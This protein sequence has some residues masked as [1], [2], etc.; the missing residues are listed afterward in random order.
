MTTPHFWA[1]TNHFRAQQIIQLEFCSRSDDDDSSHADAPELQLR[2]LSTT[3]LK[4]YVF[5]NW[6]GILVLTM[7]EYVSSPT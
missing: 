7:V 3:I 1:Q 5:P 4:P 6:N 2:C